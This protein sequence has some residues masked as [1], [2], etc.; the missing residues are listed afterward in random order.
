M[1]AGPAER[2]VEAHDEEITALILAG[3]G[4]GLAAVWFASRRRRDRFPGSCQEQ[5]PDSKGHGPSVLRCQLPAYLTK[6][7]RRTCRCLL[8]HSF[9]PPLS[10]GI[11]AGAGAPPAPPPVIAST[12][13][14]IAIPIAVRSDAMVISCSLKRVRIRSLKVLS[15]LRRR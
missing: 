2:V 5:G 3:V 9:T 11:G 8:S 4:I 12:S 13:V 6:M 14:E 1:P 15:S 7:R 10:D